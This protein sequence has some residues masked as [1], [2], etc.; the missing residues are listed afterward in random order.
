MRQGKLRNDYGRKNKA[1][2]VHGIFH[3]D[4]LGAV[5]FHKKAVN[6][7]L[8][9]QDVLKAGDIQERIGYC[10][11]RAAFQAK[12]KTDFKERM[13]LAANAYYDAIKL[14]EKVEKKERQA[15]SNHCQAMATY[16]TFWLEKDVSAKRQQLD[17]CWN[18]EKEALRVYKNADDLLNVGKTC[19]SLLIFLTNRLDLEWDAKARETIV[20]EALAYARAH[21]DPFPLHDI[22]FYW[23]VYY[24]YYGRTRKAGGKVPRKMVISQL[25]SPLTI[26][27]TQHCFNDNMFS[28]NY[29][30]VLS[31]SHNKVKS[32]LLVG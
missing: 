24:F 8:K 4:W 29:K 5:E 21:K 10:F 6:Q 2:R 3:V 19:N 22:V 31:Q 23:D 14:F 26:D 12:T 30:I 7:A 1:E 18:L 25:N 15:K 20:S 9:Q 11:Q 16:V 28:S 32:L 13:H 17:Q 27:L